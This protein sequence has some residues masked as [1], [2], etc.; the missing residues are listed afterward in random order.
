MT[1]T[2]ADALRMGISISAT[3]QGWT[4]DTDRNPTQRCR[5]TVR[6]D[7]ASLA[8]T[9]GVAFPLERL[10]DRLACPVCG[11][12]KVVVLYTAP[13]APGAAKSA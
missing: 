5:S 2:L 1:D 12:R 6:F 8:W 13:G 7:V 9:R 11:S 4:R 10:K 3:C